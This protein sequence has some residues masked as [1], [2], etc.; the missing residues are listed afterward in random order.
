MIK[1]LPKKDYFFGNAFMLYY[2]MI[3]YHPGF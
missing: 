1:A 3:I 2:S